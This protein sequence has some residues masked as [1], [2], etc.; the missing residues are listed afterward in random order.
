[1]F[2]EYKRVSSADM[3]QS[4]TLLFM[5]IRLLQALVLPTHTSTADQ[6]R[7]FGSSAYLML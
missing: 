1:M 2:C 4:G 6:G 3:D 5:P 7:S